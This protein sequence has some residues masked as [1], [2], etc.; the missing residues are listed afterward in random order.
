MDASIEFLVIFISIKSKTVANGI[1]SRK[2]FY[3]VCRLLFQDL[4]HLGTVVSF[5]SINYLE[6]F[7]VILWK[8]VN[9]KA[10]TFFL[11]LVYIAMEWSR[12]KHPGLFIITTFRLLSAGWMQMLVIFKLI[13][14]LTQMYG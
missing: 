1:L 5:C 14:S 8:F 9:E 10:V 4:I 2:E 3:L 7:F 6:N 13:S 12:G 11:N